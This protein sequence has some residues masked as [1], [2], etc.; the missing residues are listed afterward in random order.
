MYSS[1]PVV[2][3]WPEMARQFAETITRMRAAPVS[4]A[5]SGNSPAGR[6]Y[7][8][9]GG[10]AVISI[11]GLMLKRP[12]EWVADMVCD[13]DAITRAVQTAANATDVN[14][15]CLR[16]DSPGG[17]VDGLAELGDAVYAAR[18]SKPIIAQVDGMAASAAYYVAALTNEVYAHRM[19]LVGSIGT[20][21]PMYDDSELYAEMG[22]KPVMIST[23]PPERP[24]KSMG[25]PGTVI[26]AEQI[27]YAQTIVDR[28][29]KDFRRALM[30]G[31]RM[32]IPQV[33]AIADGRVF[34]PADAMQLGLIDGIRTMQDTL[35]TLRNKYGPGGL[36]TTASV[37]AELARKRL[38][39]PVE[40]R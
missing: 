21:W 20:I 28:Y 26:T 4:A 40:C 3:L 9:S 6:L 10:V 2:A 24:Y 32:S 5:A 25:W 18:A 33:D 11:Q 23:E 12:P 34:F 8:T 36:R 31:R 19:D 22:V 30:I 7:Q 1:N 17:S 38:S 39:M 37:R 15:I 29:G 35:N 13:T 16:I 27:A 14:T